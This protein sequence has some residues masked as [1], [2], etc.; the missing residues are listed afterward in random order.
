[1]RTTSGGRREPAVS[2]NDPA[3]EDELVALLVL[4]RLPRVGPRAVLRLV[5]HFGSAR[6]ALGAPRPAFEAVAGRAAAASRT[7]TAVRREVE[8][9]LRTAA[10]AGVRV[11]SWNDPSYP[12][13][14][15]QL[16]DPPPVLFSSGRDDLLD[17]GGVAVVGARRASVRACDVAHRLG[18]ALARVGTPVLSG[19]ALGIDGAAHRGTLDG[20][21]DTVA[22]LGSGI[23]VPYP[24]SHERLFAEV[25]DRGLLVSEFAPGTSATPWAFPRR[26]RIMA[27]LADAVVVVA[28]G[29][30]SGALITVDHALDLGR[31]VWAVPGPFDAAGHAGSNRLLAD[32]AKALVSIEDFCEAYRRSDT[33]GGAEAARPSSRGAGPREVE[34]LALLADGALTLDEVVDGLSIDAGVALAVLTTLELHGEVV[35]L[36]GARYRCAA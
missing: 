30:R 11:R 15:K 12:A 24:R 7:D 6:R 35:R 2:L 14:L 34:V 19:L 16:A 29:R 5:R 8:S 1:M 36:P 17:A 13:R 10:R 4:D 28:A 31:D 3:R 21:G 20:G 26:N 22:V 27:A 33:R 18:R 25:G 23:D 32:G 9:L